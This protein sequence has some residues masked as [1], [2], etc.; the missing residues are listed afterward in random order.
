M[1][2]KEE[3]IVYRNYV[4]AFIDVLGQQ[5]YFRPLKEFKIIA[6]QDGLEEVL[7]K[8]DINTAYRVNKFREDF[9]VFFNAIIEERPVPPSVPAEKIETFKELRRAN[10]KYKSFSDCMQIF[11][12]LQVVKSYTV[13]ANSI[14]GMLMTSGEMMLFSLSEK[15]AFR[16]GME[17]GIGIEIEKSEVYGPALFEAYRLESKIAQYPRI[18]VGNILIDYLNNLSSGTPQEEN[19]ESLDISLCKIMAENCLNMITEDIDGCMILDY[20]GKEFTRG[21]KEALGKEKFKEIAELA[22]IFVASENK[23]FS[24]E[25]NVKLAQRYYLLLQ[26]FLKNKDNFS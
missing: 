21:A 5:E 4:V 1:N 14:F 17:I 12:P 10:I 22:S 26:Y 13:V 20:L 19:Q 18:V 3:D 15:S 2:K 7:A 25:K 9:E 16:A 8:V 23:R 24:K 6:K 11:T